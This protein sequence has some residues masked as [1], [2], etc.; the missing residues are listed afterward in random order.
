MGNCVVC[1]KAVDWE[2]VKEEFEDLFSIADSR[3]VEAL[4]EQQQV[5]YHGMCCSMSCYEGLN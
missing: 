1:K 5:I 2:L 3:G 4:T